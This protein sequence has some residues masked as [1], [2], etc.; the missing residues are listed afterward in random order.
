MVVELLVKQKKE[1]DLFFNELDVT[2]IEDIVDIMI[3]KKNDGKAI[4][5]SGV[6]KS[7]NIALHSADM[8]KSMGFMSFALKPM[9]ALHGDI[10]VLRPGDMIFIYSK[11]GNTQELTSFM[12]HLNKIGV[13]VYGVFCNNNAKLAK[14]CNTVVVLPCGKELDNDF[15]LVPTT[16]IISFILFCNLIVSYFLK[17]QNINIYQYGKNHPSGNIGQRVWLTVKDIM[18]KLN[19]V[20]IVQENITLLDCMMKMTSK[21]TGYAIILDQQDNN[22]KM[23]GILS[24]GD[25]RR[26]L[27]TNNKEVDLNTSINPLVNRTP[28]RVNQDEKLRNVI[29]KINQNKSLSVGIPVVDDTGNF[30]GFIDNKLLMEFGNVF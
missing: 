23:F 5:W 18:Y 8:L 13:D 24:D 15:D 11:S 10:G 19:D 20:C 30:V 7:Y 1:I 17:S 27:T 4:Y 25:I 14:Y 3:Q 9:E 16:S 26:Y 28:T 22:D 6:G 2:I 12:M 21:R 29:E